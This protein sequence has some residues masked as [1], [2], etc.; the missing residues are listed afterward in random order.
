[1][2]NIITI[3]REYGCGGGEI[4]RNLAERLDWKLWDELLTCEIA[5]L[6]NCKQSEVESREE[7]VDPLY[8]RLFKSILRGS[9]EGSL[10]VHRLKLL[11]ADSILRVTEH[12]VRKAATEGNCVIVGRGSQHFLRHRDDTLRIFLYAPRQAKIARLMADGLNE[13]EAKD[14]VDTVD[15]ERGAFIEKYFHIK[16][17]NPPV[18]HAM[19][20]TVI[21]VSGVVDEILNLK[22]TVEQRTRTA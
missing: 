2:I 8:Y 12:V 17:P 14:S 5:R 22:R 21:G 3:E 6:S 19:L 1:M 13:S 9:F 10:N 7:R 11:D 18:Y 16:W 4:A 15:A 20:N